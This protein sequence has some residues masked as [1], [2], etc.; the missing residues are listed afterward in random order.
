MKELKE[1]KKNYNDSPRDEML[2]IVGDLKRHLSLQMPEIPWCEEV[3]EGTVPPEAGNVL[4][5]AENLEEVRKIL[6]DCTRCRL[7]EGRKKIV[8]GQGNP[9]A[10]LMF[11]GEGPGADEDRQGLAFVGAAGQL[12]TKIIAAIG[13]TREE[14]Y[15]AN[16]VKCRPPGNRDPKEDEIQTCIPFLRAQIRVIQPR[17]ICTLGAPASKTLLNTTA[18]ISRLR[19]RFHEL[20]GI[21]VM[22]TYHPA[23][24]L[25][26]PEQKRP[27]WEDMQKV[28][29]LYRE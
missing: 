12:L 22:P 16:I 8:F 3:Q 9:Q 27:V 10:R 13:L 20:D 5:H 25:R 28:Q 17:I 11:V 21:Q 2:Q 14:V 7:H 29:A 19:G 26:N 15:I 6:G 23:Y 4:E 1:V 24:L 18:P